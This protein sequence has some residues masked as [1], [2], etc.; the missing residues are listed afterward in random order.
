V[1]G[2][3]RDG[4][5]YDSFKLKLVMPIDTVK[6]HIERKHLQPNKK[7]IKI[8]KNKKSNITTN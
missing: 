2:K 8:Y 7:Q 3:K 6:A 5:D 4:K 1:I